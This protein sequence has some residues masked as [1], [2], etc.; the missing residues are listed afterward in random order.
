MLHTSG[1]LK[2]LWA[3]ACNTAVYILNCTGPKPV[4]SKTPLELWTGSYA[5]LGHLHVFGTEY[6]V[7]I[8]IQK[9]GT[10]GTKRVSWVNWSDIWVKRMGIKFGYLTKG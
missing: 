5:T 10:S 6:Y 7:P 8:P 4:E 1:L 9:K 3:E 2:E